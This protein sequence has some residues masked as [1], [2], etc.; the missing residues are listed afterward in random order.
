MHEILYAEGLAEFCASYKYG[1][2]RYSTID[3]WKKTQNGVKIIF[4]RTDALDA[5]IP[6]LQTRG[7]TYYIQL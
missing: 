7:F 6:H 4:F 5:F 2:I 1:W 3:L